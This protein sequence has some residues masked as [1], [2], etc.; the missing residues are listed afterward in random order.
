MHLQFWV[1][2]RVR[3]RVLGYLHILSVYKEKHLTIYINFTSGR[4][5]AK[6]ISP[7]VEARPLVRFKGGRE[8]QVKTLMRRRVVYSGEIQ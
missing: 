5:R 2:V 3:V 6:R 8:S 4:R 7:R 1:R